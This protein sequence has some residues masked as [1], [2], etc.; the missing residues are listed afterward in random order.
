VPEINMGQMVR[1]VERC[2]RDGCQVVL[3]PNA[4]GEMHD[5]EEI[6]EAI[7][8]VAAGKVGE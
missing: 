1:E 6:L 8:Q 7:L 5:P 2:S 3:V 4:G